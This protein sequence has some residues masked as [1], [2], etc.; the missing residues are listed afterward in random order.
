MLLR[1]KLGYQRS[2]QELISH[3]LHALH[4][5]K[6]FGGMAENSSFFFVFCFGLAEHRSSISLASYSAS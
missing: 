6:S 3:P 4:N 1:L 2:L 5:A